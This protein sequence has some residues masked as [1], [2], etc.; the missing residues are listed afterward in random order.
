MGEIAEVV[1]DAVDKAGESRLNTVVAVAVSLAATFTALCNVKDG[2]IVQAMAQAQANAVDAWTYYQSKSTKQ[3][4]AESMVDQLMIE[5]D[6]AGN[7]LTPEGRALLDRKMADYKSKAKQY[8]VEKA[9]IKAQAE[10]FQKQ[11]DAL[12]VRDDQFDMAEAG[13]SIAIALFGVTAL[14]Q[15]RW[16]LFVAGT[17]AVF[18]IVIGFAGFLDKNLHPDWLAKLLG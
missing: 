2:N 12:N 15:K 3:N 8:E 16:M 9:E 10:G 1:N 7:N 18:G 11:Y 4:I 6:I 13:L 14:T 5:R 17:F